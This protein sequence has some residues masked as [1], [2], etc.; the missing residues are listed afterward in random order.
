MQ[1]LE[2]AKPQDIGPRRRKQVSYNEDK[3]QKA[4]AA[5][6]QTAA[7][8]DYAAG[9]S[10]GS[11]S[12]DEVKGP[13]QMHALLETASRACAKSQIALPMGQMPVMVLYT[14]SCRQW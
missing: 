2:A 14:Q 8:S 5:Q 1:V 12:A 9:S 10:D 6:E 3:L 11:T 13:E 7:E 4:T